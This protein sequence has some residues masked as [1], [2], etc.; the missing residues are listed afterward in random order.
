VIALCIKP[1]GVGFARTDDIF[2][3]KAE[4]LIAF[5]SARYRIAPCGVPRKVS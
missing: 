1:D 4:I 3:Q 5:E 2:G